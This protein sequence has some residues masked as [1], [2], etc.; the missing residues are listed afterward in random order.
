MKSL[1]ITCIDT[2]RYKET[3]FALEKT[4]E[5]LKNKVNIECVY[6]F[7]D[8]DIPK[9]IKTK[10]KWIKIDSMKSKF[11]SDYNN[12]IFN[13]LPNIMEEDYNMIIQY[14]GFAVNSHAWT[15]KFL[16]Y[17]YIG[18]IWPWFNDGWRVG[19]GG[20]SIRSK[21]LYDAL[22]QNK[23]EVWS[24]LYRTSWLMS[25]QEDLIFCRYIR[26]VFEIEYNIKYAPE[27]L[28]DQFSI[29]HNYDSSWLGKSLGF[30][31]RHGIA[32]HYGITL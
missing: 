7:S 16:E 4:I 21:K 24:P 25:E 29:E 18:A 12:V 3:L 14:D 15:D 17:D 11:T 20:F 31:G 9:Q 32:E 30:H 27:D 28:A 6:W 22:L 23:K 5:T 2:L 8:I 10:T 13:L 19:N 26:D 1:S